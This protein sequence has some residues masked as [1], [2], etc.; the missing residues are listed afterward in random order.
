M[1]ALDLGPLPAALREL[2]AHALAPG[3]DC[4]EALEALTRHAATPGA[5]T[6]PLLLVLAVLTVEDARRLVLHRLGDAC[7]EALDLLAE[8]RA[9]G[10]GHDA[11]DR[12]V[13]RLL[14]SEEDR[15]AAL[16]R[17]LEG[18]SGEPARPTQMVELA[19]ALLREGDTHTA[20]WLLRRAGCLA[21]GNGSGVFELPRAAS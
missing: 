18:G 12:W 6:G 7:R 4:Q 15:E 19:H 13:R 16:R 8:A 3:A 17:S 2:V 14:G 21:T 10:A 20:K 1:V 11:L 5:R 9:L